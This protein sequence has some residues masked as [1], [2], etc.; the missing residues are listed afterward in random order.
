MPT[1]SLTPK[2][3]TSL[4]V[5]GVLL[6]VFTGFRLLFMARYG[7]LGLFAQPEGLRALYLGLK[8]DLRL[9]AILL[10]PFWLLYREGRPEPGQDW[11]AWVAP[12][13]L[14]LTLAVYVQLILLAM[15]D[16]RR[17]RPWLLG[18]LALVF[19]YRW[20]AKADGAASNRVTRWV[21]LVF[22][23]AV[24]GT[25][26]LVYFVDLGTYSYLHTR[27]NGTLLMFLENPAISLAMIWQSYPVIP[28]VL[29]LG[30]LLGLTAWGLRSLRGGLADAPPGRGTKVVNVLFS[31]VLIAV[32]Y[33]KW[34]RYPLRW[35]EVFDSKV[36]LNAHASLNPVLFLLETRED[37]DGGF[38]LEKVKASHPVLA[39]YFG[40]PLVY[41]A[42][43]LPSLRR[44]IEPRSPFRGDTNVVFIQL[45]TF[46][47][48]KTS[49][50]GNPLNP[51][52]FFAE[53]CARGLFFD[54]FNVVM[55]NTS[56]SMFATLFGTPDVS[57]TQNATRNPLLVN[58]HTL[59]SALKGYESA[60]FLGGSANW[61]Q[62]RAVLKNNVKN[63]EIH[64][65]GSFK[66]PV[67][68]VWG[69]SDADLLLEANENLA[70]RT[71][72]FWAYLQTSGNHPPFTIPPQFKDFELLR[73][74]PAA[75]KAAGFEGP[76]EF[77]ALRLMDYSLRKFFQ[78]AE[79][80]PYFKNTIFVL[81]GDHGIPRGSTDTR[82][83]DLTLAIHQV[84]L[85]LYAPGLIEARRD[86][87]VA[88]Q[89]DILP[90][91]MSLLGRPVETQTLGK[92][93]L[94]PAFREK[95][96]AFTFT[97]FRRP[98]RTGLIQGNHYLN[99]EPDGRPALYRLDDPMPAPHGTLP[100][101]SSEEPERTR[102]MKA[103]T[104]AIHEWSKFLLS[105]NPPLEEGL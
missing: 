95:A 4:L 78:A 70:R 15:V 64:E 74:E 3:R 103:L 35:A 98:P 33:G 93:L 83:G 11:K 39:E 10:I 72:P 92:D 67:V 100:D 28:G 65:E 9:V 81:W 23:L 7:H 59:L 55:E 46:A 75:L 26:I 29:V 84:P 101:H 45:E 22:P 54:R 82:F 14:I 31:C 61:A 86:S 69:V 73:P 56:R 40:I 85:L 79:R 53:L 49:P 90:T 80:A 36:A 52:P 17:P 94:D 104:Q 38:D 30:L 27:L 16:D 13:A 1:P 32:M 24:V 18:F 41:D 91:L 48:F 76:E 34:S 66:A 58:Q 68:D 62:I 44:R 8:F 37:M 63:L 99:L 42:Q 25:T 97:T 5:G 102:R 6:L 47:A 20:L 21:W 87:T 57:A 60:Y 50:F 12:L 19:L 51:T 105:H 43:G 96:A 71:K 77:N 88:N 2:L 89:M